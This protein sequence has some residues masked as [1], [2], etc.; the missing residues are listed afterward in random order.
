MGTSIST[1][2][3]SVRYIKAGINTLQTSPST[4]A[5]PPLLPASKPRCHYH[6]NNHAATTKLSPPLP[7]PPKTRHYYSQLHEAKTQKAPTISI[8]SPPEKARHRHDNHYDT[9]ATTIL[10]KT[11]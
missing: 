9:I 4:T 1:I 11:P 3:L 6:Y 8:T 5:K 2:E 7:P 10:P